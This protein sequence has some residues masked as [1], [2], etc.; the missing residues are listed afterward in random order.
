M[1]IYTWYKDLSKYPLFLSDE[2]PATKGSL[3][4]YVIPDFE[5]L[6]I[7]VT[8]KF[9]KLLILYGVFHTVNQIRHVSRNKETKYKRLLMWS[10]HRRVH[11]PTLKNA[12]V[13]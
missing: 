8:M 11:I 7:N 10:L 13:K 12:I 9:L 2:P 4:S 1:D 3:S 6:L 5:G